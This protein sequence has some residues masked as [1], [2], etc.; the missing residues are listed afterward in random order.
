MKETTK[1]RVRIS[2][3][4]VAEFGRYDNES[5][6]VSARIRNTKTGEIRQK[7]VSV[8]KFVRLIFSHE[9]KSWGIK[10]NGK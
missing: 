1:S 9:F 8:D 10:T 4:W 6:T 7:V 5:Q 2:G 3:P